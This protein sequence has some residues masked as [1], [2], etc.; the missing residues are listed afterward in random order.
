MSVSGPL[1][2]GRAGAALDRYVDAVQDRLADEATDRIHALLAGSLK[3]PTGY[4][5]SHIHTERSTSDR[6]VTD[7]PVVYGPWLEGLGSRNFP[8]TR[9]RG[10]GSFRKATQDLDAQ[11]GGIARDVLDTGGYGEE[12]NA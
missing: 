7:T 2:D 6:T 10:Y 5:E 8:K 3:H 11:A 4:Y 9:F 1:F 12:M